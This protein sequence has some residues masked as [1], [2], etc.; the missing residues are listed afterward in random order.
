MRTQATPGAS[1]AGSLCACALLAAGEKPATHFG[2]TH[3]VWGIVD[4]NESL[5]VVE[6]IVKLP[7]TAPQPGGMH[8]LN[9]FVDFQ[10]GA[11]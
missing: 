11:E 2:R 7:A 5:A 10:T 8:M 1:N 3:T 4:T 9:D 6:K